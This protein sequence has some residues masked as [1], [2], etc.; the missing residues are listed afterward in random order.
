MSAAT[1]KHECP[2]PSRGQVHE[3]VRA[4]R[5]ALKGRREI[6]RAIAAAERLRGKP[7]RKGTMGGRPR[8]SRALPVHGE[9]NRSI[10]AEAILNT[11][12]EGRL[13]AFSAGSHPLDEVHPLARRLQTLQSRLRGVHDN[14]CRHHH[15]PRAWHHPGAVR[16]S[17]RVY[18][19]LRVAVQRRRE[20]SAGHL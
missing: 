20:V 19:R 11:L 18:G 7:Q 17:R 16:R 4:R 10:M 9:F 6:L 8:R 13:K 14:V 1:D 3:L 2:Q 5:E 15:Q 12:G